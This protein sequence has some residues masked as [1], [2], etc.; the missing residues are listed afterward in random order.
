MTVPYI[1]DTN[2]LLLL[3]VG[4]TDVD[5]IAKHKRLTKYTKDDFILLTDTIGSSPIIFTPNTVTETSNFIDFVSDP[6]RS[7][8]RNVFNAL[9]KTSA[10]E[11]VP[12]TIAIQQIAHIELGVADNVLLEAAKNAILISSDQ[13]LFIA[14]A[15]L[16]HL[17]VSFKILQ[18]NSRLEI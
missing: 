14:A 13:D 10:E 7:E 4:L 8:I 15:V 2:L 6:I 16:N 5:Y 18:E 12:S 3:V 1:V 11:Y 17:C 9:I